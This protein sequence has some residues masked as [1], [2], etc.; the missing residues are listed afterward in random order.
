MNKT[1]NSFIINNLLIVFGLIM[2]FS[3]LTMQLGYHVGDHD[4]H[5]KG[6]EK[7][8]PQS[9]P[10]EQIRAIDTSKIVNGL[11]YTEWSTIHKFAIVVFSLIMIYHIYL[12]L[13][14]YKGVI[15][16]H[17]IRKNVQVI[18]LSVIFLLVAVTGLVP[19]FINLSGGKGILRLLFI[20]IHD[21]ISLIFI[22]YLI[23]HI[24]KRTKWFGIA[25]AKLR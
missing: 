21:K 8:K 15:T 23:L 22:I 19:L 7:V 25:Y 2:I 24:A 14:W 4:G 1:L 5:Q 20:E 10:H 9:M 18:T 3:G 16:K 17:L 11:D 12:H 6:I 13:K